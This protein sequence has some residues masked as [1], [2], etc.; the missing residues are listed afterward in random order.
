MQKQQQQ[1]KTGFLSAAKQSYFSLFHV[2]WLW[3]GFD[4]NNTIN[5]DLLTTNT[6]KLRPSRNKYS[7][8]ATCKWQIQWNWDLF[9]TSIVKLRLVCDSKRNLDFFLAKTVKQR[10]VCDKYSETETFSDSYSETE[11]SLWHTVKQTFW[12]LI[13]VTETY[14][15]QIQ[16]NWDLLVTV[17]VKLS[18]VRDRT[19]DTET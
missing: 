15:W 6:V 19:N 11:M 14:W 8:D 2:F 5:W 7:K 10:P 18:L 3:V 16:W 12:K 1:K 9:V 17:T 4:L 13:Y